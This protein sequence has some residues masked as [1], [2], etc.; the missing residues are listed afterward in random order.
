MS[1]LS[2]AQPAHHQ[3]A[4]DTTGIAAKT[5][6]NPLDDAVL[7]LAPEQLELEF[8]QL[9]RLVKLTLHDEQHDWVDIGFR[10]NPRAGES[11]NWQL[12]ELGS[13]V[14]YT[15]DWAALASNEQLVRGS[16]S[17]AFGSSAAAPSVTMEAEAALIEARNS[18]DEGTFVT[19]PR[20]EIIINR[21]PPEYDPPFTIELEDEQ[22][23]D[24]C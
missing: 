12:P 14:Y 23:P 19:S 6:T 17:F 2:Y 22:S 8:P 24:N 16:F 18:N 11:F 1:G 4:T 5:E 7:E 15:A 21:D 20:T 10:Y 13:A 3:P 9:V